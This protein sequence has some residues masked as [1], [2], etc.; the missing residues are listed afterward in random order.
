MVTNSDISEQSQT[1]SVFSSFFKA[2]PTKPSTLFTY[3]FRLLFTTLVAAMFSN[4]VISVRRGHCLPY[5][6]L[7]PEN[8]LIV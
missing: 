4:P 2:V 1:Y 7:S 6:F 3:S 5:F 8:Q